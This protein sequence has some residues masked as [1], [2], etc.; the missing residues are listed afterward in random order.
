MFIAVIYL[1]KSIMGLI[2][3]EKTARISGFLSLYAG[4]LVTCIEGLPEF[5]DVVDADPQ[6]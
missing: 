4:A 1:A 2:T 5:V 3:P 6:S